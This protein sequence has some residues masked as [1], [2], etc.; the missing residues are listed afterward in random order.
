MKAEVGQCRAEI[1]LAALYRRRSTILALIHSVERY[2]RAT[3]RPAP[4][5]LQRTFRC[6]PARRVYAK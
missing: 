3:V 1:E 6:R 5:P 2:Q 4:R